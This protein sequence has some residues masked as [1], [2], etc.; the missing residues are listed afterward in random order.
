MII[1][2]SLFALA[3]LSLLAGCS[4]SHGGR[5][6]ITGT[7]KLKGQPIKDGT[8]S[9]EPLE[10]QATRASAPVTAGAFKIPKASGLVP[11]KYLIRVSAGDGKTAINPVNAD[12]PP[13][14]GGGTNVISKELVP[15]SWNVNSKEERSVVKQDDPNN[16]DFNIP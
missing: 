11:G 2:R 9:F 10:G 12:Q 5:Q 8:V 7:A 3:L 15:A 14:P 4:D 6:E 16:F 13:G 1:A